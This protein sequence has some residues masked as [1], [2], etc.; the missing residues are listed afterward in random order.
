M[1]NQDLIVNHEGIKA[2]AEWFEDEGFYGATAF[3]SGSCISAMGETA[4]DMIAA[5][6]ESVNLYLS[7]EQSLSE[8]YDTYPE[9]FSE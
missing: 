3:D 6:V 1:S 8:K 9:D 2:I 7:G 5:W 4:E